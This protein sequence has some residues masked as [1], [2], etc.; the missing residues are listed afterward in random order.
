[1]KVPKIGSLC[2]VLMLLA[3]C[4]VPVPARESGSPSPTAVAGSPTIAPSPTSLPVP[5]AT[6]TATIRPPT[7]SAPTLTPPP[8]SLTPEALPSQ[9]AEI[10]DGLETEVEELRGLSTDVP[11]ARRLMTPQELTAYLERKFTEE[12]PPAEIEADVRTMAAFD[13]V[14]R[15]LDL[16]RVLLDLY[17]SQI[18]GLYDEEEN[19]FYIISEGEFDLADRITFVHEYVHGLQDIFYQLETFVDDDRMNDD[20]VL[21]RMA[22]AEGDATFVMSDY[23]LAHLAEWTPQDL[24]SLQSE[25]VEGDQ[26]ALEAAPPIIRETFEFPYV[27]GLQF[28][29]YLQEKGWKTVDP[30]FAKPP[31]STEQILHP[32][33]YLSED[34]PQMI[35]LPPLTD[36]LGAGWHLVEVETLGE[37]Q[38]RLYL[39]QQVGQEMAELASEGWD[40]D[41]YALYARGDEDVLVLVSAWDSRADRD[42][43][44]AAWTQYAT[45][46]YGRSPERTGPAGLWWQTPGQTALLTWNGVRA[47]IILG[48]SRD[49]IDKVVAALP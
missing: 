11:I 29:E 44:V 37:F 5:T 46:K 12:Y 10:M 26:E 21:A 14:P 6:N 45:H 9:V 25:E 48:P 33:K 38:T 8:P 7:A 4:G 28:V 30:A 20:Q 39:A 1:M 36:T 2:L 27:Y 18:L 47:I 3:G 41:Q 35:A 34:E 19:L 42:E 40:G 49:L 32:E 23:L 17:S 24:A 16:R 22:L 13:F 31:Q 43:F 15:D